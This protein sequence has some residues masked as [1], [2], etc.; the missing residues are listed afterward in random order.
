MSLYWKI[1]IIKK[2]GHLIHDFRTAVHVLASPAQVDNGQGGIIIQAYRGYGTFNEFYLMGR[3]FKQT[4][5][6]SSILAGT[7]RRDLVDVARR[8]FRLGVPD[9]VVTARFGDAMHHTMTDRHGYFVVHMQ[10]KDQVLRENRWY[11]VN[12]ELNHSRNELRTTGAFYV[13]PQSARYVVISDIDDTVVFTGITNK[14]AMLMRLFLHGVESKVA[15]PGV[16]A[17]YRALHHGVSGQELNPMLYVSRG[18]WSIYEILD[19]F[20]NLHHIPEGPVLF[21]REWGMSTKRPFPS[22]GRGHKLKLIRRMLAIYKDLPFILIGDSGQRDPE[23][24]ARIVRENPGRVL[25]IYIRNIHPDPERQEDIQDL[26]KEVIA[27]G[28]S[29]ILAADSFAMAEHAA[30]HNFISPEAL[31]EVFRERKE[32]AGEVELQPVRKIGETTPQKTR[33]AIEHGAIEKTLQKVDE[34]G[35]PPNVVVKSEDR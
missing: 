13:P 32:Q 21:L 6:G 2:I 11:T 30:Q 24:Y 9:V 35:S 10:L 19:K 7:F 14:A 12:L 15:F 17:L 23:I 5:Y 33:E 29:L 26:A 20:F 16:A 31:A 25:A 34:T 3:V 4:G 8:L 22:R 18:P 28:S 1:K 27:A